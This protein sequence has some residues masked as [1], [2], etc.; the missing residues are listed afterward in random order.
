M[1]ASV[2]ALSLYALTSDA[3]SSHLIKLTNHLEPYGFFRTSA[4][5]D[6]RES[7]A[8]NYDLFYSFPYDK[9]INL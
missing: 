4:I 2:A 8:D 3:Q 5:F 9:E 6:A 7:K 1:M